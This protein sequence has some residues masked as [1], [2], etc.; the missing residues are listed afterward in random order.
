MLTRPTKNTSTDGLSGGRSRR[1]VRA[2]AAVV[3]VAAGLFVSV[4]TASAADR[5][6]TGAPKGVRDVA[7]MLRGLPQQG[8]ALGS[9][10]ASVTL[11]EFADLQCPYCGDW[12]RDAL[13]TLI[14][15]YVRSG[16]VR[17]V[18]SGLHFVGPDSETALRTALAAAPQ[19]RFWNVL[20]LLFANQGTENT[21]W[22]TDSL[23]RAIGRNVAGLDVARTMRARNSVGVERLLARAAALADQASVQSTPTFAVGRTGSSL[24]IVRVT[25]LTAKGLRPAL[26]AALRG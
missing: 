16:K 10:R 13:P 17:I 11:M 1:L 20:E 23:L 2:F 26:D 6:G 3:L 9:T 19:H 24:T 5:Q 22:V 25:S 8:T 7:T 18:F 15:D 14:R 4:P 12:A 21:G